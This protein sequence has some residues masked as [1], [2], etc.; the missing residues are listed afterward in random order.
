MIYSSKSE[1]TFIPKTFSLP[2]EPFSS[3]VGKLFN[4]FEAKQL[5]LKSASAWKEE[6]RIVIPDVMPAGFVVIQ[7]ERSIGLSNLEYAVLES[8]GNNHYTVVRD[9]WYVYSYDQTIPK[10]KNTSKKSF[11]DLNSISKQ[12]KQQ[13]E[14]PAP[15]L[16]GHSPYVIH[17]NNRENDIPQTTEQQ[18][19]GATR[20]SPKRAF[21]LC[22]TY[23]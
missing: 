9:G 12:E 18:Q 1:Q 2:E 8:L 4:Y 22:Y 15:V 13:K 19:K 17:I 10:T 7:V 5:G 20:T 23:Y 14:L 3:R 21:S 16:N 6:G 11:S